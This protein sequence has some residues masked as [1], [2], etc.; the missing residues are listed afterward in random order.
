[1]PGGVSGNGHSWAGRGKKFNASRRPSPRPAHR[2]RVRVGQRLA[3]EAAT[4]L[5]SDD[6]GVFDDKRLYLHTIAN[7]PAESQSMSNTD[8]I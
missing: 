5:D 8:T 4:I 1:M 6:Y 2:R 7:A 3:C